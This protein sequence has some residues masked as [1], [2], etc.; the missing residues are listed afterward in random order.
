MDELL[1]LGRMARRLC[2]TQKWLKQAADEGRVPCLRA[3]SRY[4]FSAAAVQAA[5]TRE[6]AKE[7]RD[8]A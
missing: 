4:L 6:A 3:D 5:L 7:V 1:S 2:V 8:N